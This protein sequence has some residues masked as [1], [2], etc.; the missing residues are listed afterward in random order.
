MFGSMQTLIIFPVKVF[1]FCYKSM[2]D[3]TPAKNCRKPPKNRHAR[4]PFSPFYLRK[5]L[6]NSGRY[7]LYKPGSD[8]LEMDSRPTGLNM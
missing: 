3:N 6:T 7:R 1:I 8:W 5:C 2:M 4:P